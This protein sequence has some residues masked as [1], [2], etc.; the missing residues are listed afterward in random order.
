MTSIAVAIVMSAAVSVGGICMSAAGLVRMASGIRVVASRCGPAS[1]S[2]PLRRRPLDRRRGLRY[3]GPWRLPGPDFH[4]LAVVS[5]SLGYVM[6]SSPLL[7]APELLGA[8]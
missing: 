2:A 8:R 3:Q 5:L 4:R 6:G 1:R 7:M